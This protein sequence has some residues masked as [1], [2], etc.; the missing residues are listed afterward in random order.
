M[1]TAYLE[2]KISMKEINNFLGKVRKWADKQKDIKAILLVG[3]YARGQAHNDSDIDLILLTNEPDK[4]LNDQSFAGTF[5]D[6]SIIEKEF[7]GKVTSLR[8]WYKDSFEVELGITIPAWITEEPLDAGTLRTITD[9]AKVIIDKIGSLEEL[10]MS[11]RR[12]NL[13]RYDDK[14]KDLPCDQLHYLFRSAGWTDGSET[15]E[16]KNNFNLPFINSTLVISAWEN[17]RLVGVVRVLSDKVIRSV[18]YDLVVEP[19]FQ[20]R[21]IGK[22]LIKRSIEHYPHTEWLVQT[23]EKI[24]NFY[25]KIGFSKYKGVVLNIPSKWTE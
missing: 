4:Y 10:I 7:W 3:S 2:G 5:G 11:V 25:E 13:I 14:R 22:E 6:I 15:D 17:E 8:I 9:G 21:G 20:G 12:R 19:E 18:I 16:M 24:A 1:G 23:T